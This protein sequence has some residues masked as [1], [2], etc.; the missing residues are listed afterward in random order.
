MITPDKITIYQ[1]TGSTIETER[2]RNKADMSV[3]FEHSYYH[4]RN[5]E[6]LFTNLKKFYKDFIEHNSSFI[7]N[8]LHSKTIH[9]TI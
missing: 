8:I 9:I 2:K 3:S 7:S 4:N 6:T 5:K 1:Y